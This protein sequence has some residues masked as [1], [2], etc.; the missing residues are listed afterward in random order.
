MRLTALCVHLDCQTCA[1]SIL[2]TGKQLLYLLTFSNVLFAYTL[3][4]SSAVLW[5]HFTDSFALRNVSF[6]KDPRVDIC[7]NWICR[8]VVSL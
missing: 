1:N 8:K 4:Y 7:M 6:S 3:H 2:L 5:F